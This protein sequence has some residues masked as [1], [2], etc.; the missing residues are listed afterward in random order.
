MSAFIRALLELQ[1]LL[2]SE[3]REGDAVEDAVGCVADD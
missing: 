3:V 2:W 1:V